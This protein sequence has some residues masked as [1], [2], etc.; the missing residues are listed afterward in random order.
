MGTT[1]SEDRRFLEEVIGSRV[2]ESAID[3]IQ[4]NLNPSDVFTERDLDSW[5]TLNDYEKIK[6]D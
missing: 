4:N 6:D 3:W 2:L 1:S 5:A